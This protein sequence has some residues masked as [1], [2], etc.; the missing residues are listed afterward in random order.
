MLNLVVSLVLEAFEKHVS[1]SLLRHSAA[2]RTALRLAVDAA[3][4]ISQRAMAG[5][6]MQWNHEEEEARPSP[7]EMF[8]QVVGVD[9]VAQTSAVVDAVL[10][11]TVG[12]MLQHSPTCTTNVLHTIVAEV[13]AIRCGGRHRPI[14]PKPQR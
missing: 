7:A 12:T 5:N 9:V 13:V 4:S 11:A 6:G 1:P 2:E 3:V 8:T 10:G 14:W